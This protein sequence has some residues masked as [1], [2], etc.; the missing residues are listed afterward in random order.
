M[1]TLHTDRLLLRPFLDADGEDLYALQS[2]A[3]VMRFWDS[4]PWTDRSRIERFL[5]GCRQMSDDGSGVRIAVA[6]RSDERFI[7][8][9]TLTAR[10]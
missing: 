9:C 1:P 2:N 6:R 10:S 7:G 5:A 4:P 3:Q 8:W